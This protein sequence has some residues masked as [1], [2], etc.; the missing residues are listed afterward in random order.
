MQA[1]REG[2]GSLVLT[3]VAVAQIVEPRVEFVEWPF[4]EGQ[5]V[6]VRSEDRMIVGIPE[7]ASSAGRR[8]A[9]LVAALVFLRF[10]KAAAVA[11]ATRHLVPDDAL[12]AAI[13]LDVPGGELARLLDVPFE[14]VAFRMAEVGAACG[15][16]H[17]ALADN[18]VELA[19]FRRPARGCGGCGPR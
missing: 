12:Q 6:M 16:D 10:D 18:V 13:R 1:A 14:V 2:R 11:F 7:G 17:D 3:P 4:S 15:D 19:S 8:W 9:G 5:I